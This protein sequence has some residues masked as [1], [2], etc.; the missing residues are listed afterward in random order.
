MYEHLV[1]PRPQH[2][3]W[4]YAN[5]V[6]TL[7]GKVAV[8]ALNDG[9]W[10]L[11]SQADFTTMMV[12]RAQADLLVHGRKTAM[13]YRA[14]S[15]LEHPDFQAQ[16]RKAKKDPALPYAVFSSHRASSLVP[17]LSSTSIPTYLVS[18]HKTL[19]TPL[20]GVTTL[21]PCGKKRAETVKRFL[22]WSQEQGHKQILLE[23]GPM[24]MQSFVEEGCLDELFLTIAPKL[25]G[26]A[27]HITKT[28]LDDG[29]FAP[30]LVRRGRLISCTPVADE[31]F[32]RYRFT[33]V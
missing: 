16:R 5:A 25:V 32:L 24:L 31:I 11:G 22:T 14:L 15:R 6:M 20:R 19:P 27:P 33:D 17:F 21:V 4:V 13:V 2:R 9:Y 29:V 8:G 3:P 18:Q 12:L 7:D 26:G 30:N 23:G 10:P 1:F 28:L